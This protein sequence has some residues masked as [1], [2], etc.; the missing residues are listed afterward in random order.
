MTDWNSSW[1]RSRSVNSS[2]FFVASSA[3]KKGDT[4][5]NTILCART[6]ESP[7]TMTT[8]VNS[9]LR[10][11]KEELDLKWNKKVST[12]S[13]KPQIDKVTGTLSE[14]GSSRES[15]TENLV[16]RNLCFHTPTLQSSDFRQ[17]AAEPG[18]CWISQHELQSNLVECIVINNS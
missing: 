8:S 16:F 13:G 9:S 17:W 2:S 11:Q 12:K 18:C 7:Q 4:A 1:L 10:S 15:Y 6:R 14:L 5:A 3:L